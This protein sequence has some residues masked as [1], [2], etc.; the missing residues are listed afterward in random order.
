[1][2]GIIYRAK[3]PSIA[4]SFGQACRGLLM[5]VAVL[6]GPGLQA[7][8]S[9]EYPLSVSYT[10][11]DENNEITMYFSYGTQLDSVAPSSTL[12]FAYK[13]TDF[14]IDESASDFESDSTGSWFIEG[15]SGWS[16]TY[17]YN[18]ED[19]VLRVSITRGD[20]TGTVGGYG[21]ILVTR[22]IVIIEIEIWRRAAPAVWYPQ[23]QWESYPNPVKDRMS[24]LSRETPFTQVRVLS[25]QGQ[26]VHRWRGQQHKLS[27]DLGHLP[28]GIY[29]LEV[30]A[31]RRHEMRRLQVSH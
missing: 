7:Q 31:D 17:S 14:A 29:T 23:W 25:M 21:D 28:R 27:L 1:M 13:C 5:I 8:P 18:P 15:N 2:F 3:A 6:F 20:G 26:E 30:W 16:T 4:V 10:E 19:S 12:S 9:N 11:P 22:G 24:L